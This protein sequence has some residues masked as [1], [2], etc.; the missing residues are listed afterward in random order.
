MKN[1]NLP[2]LQ[3]GRLEYKDL[4]SAVLLLPSVRRSVF[5]YVEAKKVPVTG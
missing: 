3:S 5:R 1:S 2:D 4:S